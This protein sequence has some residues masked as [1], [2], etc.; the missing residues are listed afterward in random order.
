[1]II[2][3]SLGGQLLDDERFKAIDKIKTVGST[4]MA[5]V[6]LMPDMRILDKDDSANYYMTMLTELV[7]AF[8]DKLASINENSYNSFTLRVGKLRLL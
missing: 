7:F 1:M 2:Y 3:F 5:A 4:F 8:K 6:G